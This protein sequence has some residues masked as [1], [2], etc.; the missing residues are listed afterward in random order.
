MS[1][2]APNGTPSGAAKN[3]NA[4]CAYRVTPPLNPIHMLPDASSPKERG[5]LSLS[6]GSP[7][8]PPRSS[9]RSSEACHR[10]NPFVWD[11]VVEIQILPCESSKMRYT[12]DAARPSCIVYTARGRA[13]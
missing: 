4:P 11:D 2:S 10:A 7:G 12:C 6:D 8:K 9:T 13:V 1:R 3:V 5:R